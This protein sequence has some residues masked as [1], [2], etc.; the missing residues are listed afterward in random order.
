MFHLVIPM[1]DLYFTA[2]NSVL[3]ERT[4]AIEEILSTSSA[5][6]TTLRNLL[7]NSPDLARGLCRIQYGKVCSIP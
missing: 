7:R 2:Y 6:L 3:E 4:D 1:L 5:K